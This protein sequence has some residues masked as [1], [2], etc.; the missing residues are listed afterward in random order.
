MLRLDRRRHRL[1]ERVEDD[2]VRDP[3]KRVQRQII[4]L[5]AEGL[6]E[7]VTQR[8]EAE[9]RVSDERGRQ[10]RRPA[11]GGREPKGQEEAVEPRRAIDQQGVGEGRGVPLIRSQAAWICESASSLVSKMP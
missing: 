7:L 11:Q 2:A 8:I 10:R 1:A 4:G 6:L 9:E 5:Q 3:K